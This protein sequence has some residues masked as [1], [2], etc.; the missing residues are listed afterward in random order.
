MLGDLAEL[1]SFFLGGRSGDEVQLSESDD[2]LESGL[3][4]FLPLSVGGR[5]SADVVKGDVEAL[6]A[7]EQ[8]AR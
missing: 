5:S 2:S 8:H 7:T 6:E 3:D 1:R 4:R